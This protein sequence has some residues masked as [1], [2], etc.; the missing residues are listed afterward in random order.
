MGAAYSQDLRDRV[1]AAYAKGMSTKP[2]TELFHVSGAWA[3]R[4]K[5]RLNQH[6]ERSPRAM[7]GLRVVKVD[8]EL[9]R[10]WVKE[11]PDAT[12]RELHQ[13]M[14]AERGIQCSESAI[15]MALLRL[16]LS[17]KKRRSMPPSR[18]GQMWRKNAAIGRTSSRRDKQQ[19]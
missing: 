17:F 12:T 14:C 19:T 8:M 6:G 10:Q 11:K 15:G 9:L 1:L 13:R 5:Q 7:G 2:I 16:G 3:R 4:V 18:I